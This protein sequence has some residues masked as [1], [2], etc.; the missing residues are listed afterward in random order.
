MTA[1]DHTYRWMA[2]RDVLTRGQCRRL[3]NSPGTFVPSTVQKESEGAVGPGRTSSGLG[4]PHGPDSDW[5]FSILHPYI[6]HMN[7]R[8]DFEVAGYSEA[9]VLR[10]NVG[11]QYD[12]H[13]DMGRDERS[14]RKLSLVVQL[15]EH[16]DYDGGELQCTPDLGPCPR[17]LGS[18]IVFPS[19]IPHRV[20][21]VTRGERMSL[22]AWVHGDHPFR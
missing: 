14:T 16:E 2:V 20:T 21:E 9:Q 1:R 15:S 8:F 5:L 18:L 17:T 4:L 19:F 6:E 11:Q 3:R 10:Y 13:V 12:W 22:V 7:R